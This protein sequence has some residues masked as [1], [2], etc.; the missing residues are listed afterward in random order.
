MNTELMISDRLMDPSKG[1]VTVKDA[2]ATAFIELVEEKTGI[3]YFKHYQVVCG[4][5][6]IKK[7]ASKLEV[8]AWLG[9]AIA[10]I[11]ALTIVINN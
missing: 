3:T 7:K 8:A 5:E 1:P 9:I 4:F 10:A 11:T 2:D 6:R